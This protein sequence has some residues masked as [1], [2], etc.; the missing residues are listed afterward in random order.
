MSTDL[1]SALR[2]IE[3]AFGDRLK[4]G[5]VREGR[6]RDATSV[7]VLPGS[8]EEVE[9]LAEVAGRFSVP[10]VALGA[11]TAGG[12]GAEEGSILLRFDL[13]RGVHIRG[14]DEMWVRAEAGASWLELE[15]NLGTRGWGLAV[16]PTSAPRA[17][18]GGW[19]AVDGIGV[20]SYQYGMLSENVLSADV[21]LAEG[22]R[23]VSGEE[24]GSVLE[25]GSVGGIVVAA[26]LRTRRADQ[27][28]PFA[29][30]FGS[31]EDLAGAVTDV[32]RVGAPL[33][34]L[35]FLN[36]E[37]ARARGLGEDYLLF[38]AYSG[39]KVQAVE[40]ALLDA[41][42]SHNGRTLPS[43]D[44]YR[45]WG[46]RFFPVA[47]SHP[48]PVLANRSIVSVARIPE[49]LKS[50]TASAIQGTI[51]CSGQVLILDLGATEEEPE[52]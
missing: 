20:G 49:A 27:D 34:H 29:I 25:S 23:T 19:L 16:Y 42:A 43:A 8:V 40:G 39:E 12:A 33:W 5:A 38:G 22:C 18:V 26:T 51:D 11:G 14:S 41:A 21:V 36:G 4:R 37:M 1:E 45:V 6:S 10:L 17:T 2:T 35:A 15:N 32:H 47:P 9:F 30:A 44:A 52:L 50:H 3:E 28:V 7:S 48:T 46:Q 31:L 24:L 13:M